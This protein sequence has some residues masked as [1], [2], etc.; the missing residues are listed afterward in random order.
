[1]NEKYA[2][3]TTADTIAV[4]ILE[5]SPSYR[6]N[7]KRR[8]NSQRWDDTRSLAHYYLENI[9]ATIVNLYVHQNPL[10]SWLEYAYPFIIGW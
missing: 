3:D 2:I 6:P 8:S 7:R 9:F 10:I 4:Y 5:I 1:L